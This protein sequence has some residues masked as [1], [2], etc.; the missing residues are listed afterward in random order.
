M[1]RP[2]KN[3]WNKENVKNRKKKFCPLWAP[4]ARPQG[5]PYLG[6]GVEYKKKTLDDVVCITVKVDYAKF[7]TIRS[8][9]FFWT[10]FGFENW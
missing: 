4:W 9:S 7:H 3:F 8:S 10:R 6:S 2:P 1:G 5:A